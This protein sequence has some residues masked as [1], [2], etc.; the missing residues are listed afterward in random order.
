[1]P[2]EITQITAVLLRGS[3]LDRAVLQRRKDRMEVAADA[4]LNIPGPDADS[5]WP[6]DTPGRLKEALG[7]DS[8]S[9]TIGLPSARALFRVVQLPTVED[10]ELPGMVDLQVDKFSPFPLDEMEVSYEVLEAG[11]TESRVLIAAVQRS[12]IDQ[13]AEPF[14]AADLLPDRIDIQALGWWHLLQAAGKVPTDEGHAFLILDR[15]HSE[16]ILSSNGRPAILRDLGS[17]DP[18][19]DPAAYFADLAEEVAFSL[20]SLESDDAE[21]RIDRLTLWH[22]DAPPEALLQK[23]EEA[24]ACEVEAHS[25]ASLPSLSEGLARRTETHASGINLA[26]PE[27]ARERRSRKLKARGLTA[28]LVLLGLWIAGIAFLYISVQ[29]GR[30]RI[31][32]LQQEADT[33]DALALQI[34]DLKDR[35]TVLETRGDRRYSPLEILREISLILPEGLEIASFNYNKG[36]DV[37]IRG[38]GDNLIG[39]NKLLEGLEKSA[40]FEAAEIVS[41]PMQRKTKLGMKTTYHFKARLPGSAEEDSAQ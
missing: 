6:E 1:M 14:L 5:V 33:K 21:A 22:W 20:T 40:L 37:S 38:Q 32:A 26:P 41:P 31:G 15:D 19:T 12:V 28:A 24:C 25:L 23:L 29:S 16:L 18:G 9:L 3:M 10:D 13:L 7:S 17:R 8:G 2:K 27:W 36:Q 34:R 35:V 39:V 4:E 11:E 30:D